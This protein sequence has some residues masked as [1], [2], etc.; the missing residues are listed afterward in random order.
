MRIAAPA[1]T[2]ER[3]AKRMRILEA[4]F[5]AF[6]ES[7]YS[8][9]STLEIATRAKVSKRELYALVGDKQDILVCCITERATRMRSR[10]AEIPKPQSRE[11]LEGLLETYGTRLLSEATHPTVV[12]MHRLA[13]A[14][15]T[16]S[17]EVARALQS[18]ARQP[19]RRVLRGI[20]LE[21]RSQGLLS[22]DPAD[23]TEQF[24]GILWGD[25]MMNLLLGDVETPGAAELKRCAEYAARALLRLNPAC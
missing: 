4:A 13:I 24:M 6:M 21:A 7:G 3:A 22:G 5:A 23:M 18:M 14:E 25:L 12:S 1:E 19:I 9:T 20:L 8:D 16:R 11:A 10:P 17:P 15:A 2:G